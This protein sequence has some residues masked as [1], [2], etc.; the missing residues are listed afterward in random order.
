MKLIEVISYYNNIRMGRVTQNLTRPE[1]RLPMK[2][3]QRAEAFVR[4]M[5]RVTPY[6]YEGLY[7]SFLHYFIESDK[8]H[9]TGNLSAHL[10][11][12]NHEW[13]EVGEEMAEVLWDEFERR[14]T[15]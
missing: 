6:I 8:S 2:T 14:I 3:S 4:D 13:G 15:C 11:Q 7:G 10:N 1:R 5:E 12:V 9:W